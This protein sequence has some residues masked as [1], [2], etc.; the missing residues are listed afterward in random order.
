MTIGLKAVEVD[1]AIGFRGVDVAICCRLVFGYKV[2]RVAFCFIVFG[3]DEVSLSDDSAQDV[4]PY[5]PVVPEKVHE[6]EEEHNDD[7]DVGFALGGGEENAI[8]L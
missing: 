2:E 7:A 3:K 6:G 5:F 8:E 1:V 4:D